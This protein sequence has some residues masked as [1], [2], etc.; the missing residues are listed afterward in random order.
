MAHLIPW[1]NKRSGEDSGEQPLARLRTEMDRLFESFFREPFGALQSAWRER[2]G[3]TPAVDVSETEDGVTV[4]AELPGID[5]KDLDVSILGNELVLG[6]EKKES[7]EQRE[8]GYYHSE[9]RY[10]SFRRTVPLPQ[11]VDSSQVDAKYENG[12]LT[13]QMKKS[14]EAMPKRIEVRTK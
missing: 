3:W 6:G 9:T 8:K 12:V 10:G 2:M 13:L 1:R 11:G 5:P 4:R 7:T 14:P